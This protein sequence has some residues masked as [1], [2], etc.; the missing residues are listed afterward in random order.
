MFTSVI[1]GLAHLNFGH[2]FPNWKMVIIAGIHG[3][4]CGHAYAQAGSV[5]ASMVTHALVVTTWKVFLS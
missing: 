5:R 1:F 4:F 3:I 2:V